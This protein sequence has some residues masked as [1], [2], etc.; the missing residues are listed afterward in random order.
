MRDNL[1]SSYAGSLY[2]IGKELGQNPDAWK[3]TEKQ[4]EICRK[5]G[6]TLQSLTDEE[7][8]YIVQVARDVAGREW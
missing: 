1:F 7:A 3:D 5:W 2:N 6:R 8:Q 4:D